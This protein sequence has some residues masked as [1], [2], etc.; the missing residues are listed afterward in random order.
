MNVGALNFRLLAAFFAK[1]VIILILQRLRN[2]VP[3]SIKQGESLQEQF[4]IKFSAD[5]VSNFCITTASR[6]LRNLKKV[7]GKEI[8]PNQVSSFSPQTSSKR[9]NQLNPSS[10]PFFSCTREQFKIKFS[11]DQVSN[12]CITTASRWICNL[13]KVLGEEIKP[14]QVSSFSLQTS[15]KGRNQLNPSSIPSFW[16]CFPFR[17]HSWAIQNQVLSG[18][19]LQSLHY[20]CKSLTP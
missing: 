5:Q 12:L 8:K 4:K 16:L 17:P 14:N 3:S 9:R 2:T 6:W 18:S 13:E 20:N 7:L 1:A 19:N 11:A 15:S 10:F